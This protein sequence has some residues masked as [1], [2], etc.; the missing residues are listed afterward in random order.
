MAL[1]N[2]LKVLPF[3]IPKHTK[4]ALILQEDLQTAF[5]GSLHQHPE[6]Q[7]SLVMEGSGNLIAGDGMSSFQAG[8]VVVLAGNLPH[9]F[10]S[11]EL[12][13]QRAHMRT[14]FF[15]K[16]GFGPAFFDTE[17]LKV[18]RKLF[19]HAEM[20][21]MVS[22]NNGQIG[23]VFDAIWKANKLDRFVLFITLRKKN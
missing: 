9:V 20:G 19:K 22:D 11:H 23:Q 12:P 2:K 6:F 17:E 4:D 10:N 13:G 7:I 15:T 21:Y 14:I 18:T 1:F 16:E 8:D 5:Y 3:T